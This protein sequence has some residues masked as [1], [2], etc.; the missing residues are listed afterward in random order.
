MPGYPGTF[1]GELTGQH[2]DIIDAAENVAAEL[3]TDVATEVLAW[4]QS[5]PGI[6]ST[7]I[8]A[9]TICTQSHMNR[10]ISGSE[11][12]RRESQRLL[13]CLLSEIVVIDVAGFSGLL[14]EAGDVLLS[15]GGE[16]V[17][18]SV[19]DGAARILKC[20]SYCA[21]IAGRKRILDRAR[22]DQ[23]NG[24]TRHPRTAPQFPHKRRASRPW[25]LGLIRPAIA[26]A[27]CSCRSQ[28]RLERRRDLQPQWPSRGR[29]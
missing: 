26:V 1:V 10:R 24:P 13:E 17:Y 15:I 23:W 2:Y 3:G 16:P 18:P 21:E 14:K 5:R 20:W 19:S 28:R 4:V 8:D 29:V 27:L 22:A 7:V 25:T 12:L 6:T 9:S 11:V